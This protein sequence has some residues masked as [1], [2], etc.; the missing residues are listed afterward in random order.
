MA[1]RSFLVLGLAATTAVAKLCGPD[2][3]SP[4]PAIDQTC[5]EDILITCNLLFSGLPLYEDSPLPLLACVDACNAD[6]Q[7]T[8]FNWY[9]GGNCYHAHPSDPYTP[10]GGAMGW[11]GG[12]SGTC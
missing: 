11:I 7:C 3:S 5:R 1:V 8:A 6:P 2:L 4:C 12:Y 9:P 10:L